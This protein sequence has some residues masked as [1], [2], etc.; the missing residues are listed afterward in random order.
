MFYRS[1][2]VDEKLKKI[3]SI[4]LQIEKKIKNSSE[5]ADEEK[6]KRLKVEKTLL[7]T[8]QD[9]GKVLKEKTKLE[10]Q[11]EELKVVVQTNNLGKEKIEVAYNKNLSELESLK[12]TKR[13]LNDT[14]DKLKTELKQ[15]ENDVNFYK[16]KSTS[17]EEGFKKISQAYLEDKKKNKELA[18]E[19]STLRT[20][21]S[22]KKDEGNQKKLDSSKLAE[23]KTLN[24]ELK[25]EKT[26]LLAKLE[27]LETSYKGLQR[28]LDEKNKQISALKTNSVKT[29]QSIPSK[30]KEN[31]VD[32]NKAAKL[33]QAELKRLQC[34]AGEVDGFWGAGSQS[35]LKNF[36][37]AAKIKRI[38]KFTSLSL[39]KLLKSKQGKLCDLKKVGA[40]K[41]EPEETCLIDCE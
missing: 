15:K 24:N 23:I 38:E 12:D 2:A 26:S 34:Y 8:A 25:T 22:S 33:I 32:E 4:K 9:L 17:I 6:K 30:Q 27:E 1:L 28:Q 7:N 29:T 39:L 14:I 5:I 11:L 31:K 41:K 37:N 40:L 19:I 3:S 35:A 18:S 20:E 10:K 21:L 13:N 36:A 16:K